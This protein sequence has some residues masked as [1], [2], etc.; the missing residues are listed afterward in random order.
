MVFVE[1]VAG[2]K[3]ATA[4][5]YEDITGRDRSGSGWLHWVAVR[6]EYQ[7]RGLSKRIAASFK[8]GHLLQSR[9]TLPDF[10]LFMAAKPSSNRV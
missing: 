6:R 8:G 7:G 3:V 5:A 10:P 1:N 4:T 2:E 9:M